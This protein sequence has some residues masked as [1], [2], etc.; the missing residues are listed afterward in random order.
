MREFCRR[1]VMRGFAGL[2]AASLF[3]H[4]VKKGGAHAQEVRRP[5]ADIRPRAEFVFRNAHVMTMDP[6]LGDIPGG[7]VHVRGGEI[8]SVGATSTRPTRRSS[9]ATT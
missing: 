1:D 9:P 8:V 4:D 3:A 6:A 5:P 7:S 2:S